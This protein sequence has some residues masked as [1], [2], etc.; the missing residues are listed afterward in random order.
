[1]GGGFD[2]AICAQD[3][4]AFLCHWHHIQLHALANRRVVILESDHHTTLPTNTQAENTLSSVLGDAHKK[5]KI[6]EAAEQGNA[7]V[8]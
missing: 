4:R 2:I 8:A 5:L 6:M 1:M 3:T 7:G